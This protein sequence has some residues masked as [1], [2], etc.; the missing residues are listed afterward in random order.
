[1]VDIISNSELAGG[2]FPKDQVYINN[3]I[4]DQ[5]KKDIYEK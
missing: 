1:M 5:R 3:F 2:F 4:L